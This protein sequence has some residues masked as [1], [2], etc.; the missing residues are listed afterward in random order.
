MWENK[1]KSISDSKKGKLLTQKQHEAISKGMMGHVVSEKTK[2][3]LRISN[4]NKTQKHSIKLKCVN[5]ITD[6]EFIFNNVEHA[7]RE[8]N[9]TRY[10]L[11]QNK[12]KN[13]NVERID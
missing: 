4:L 3:K 7:R 2:E 12:L 10:E 8:L 1:G 9:C 13:F 5:L 6:E 11:L